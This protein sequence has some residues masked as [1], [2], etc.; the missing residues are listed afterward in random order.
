MSELI[1]ITPELFARTK[2]KEGFR[3]RPY[4]CPT[5][6]WTIGYGHKITDNALLIVF[7]WNTELRFSEEQADEQLLRDLMSAV[8]D[9]KKLHVIATPARQ[10]ALIEMVFNLGLPQVWQFK[11]MLS[12]IYSG[13]WNR[14]A[15]EALNSQWAK[16]VGKRAQEI[17]EIFRKG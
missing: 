6:H 3:D 11:K 15:K 13:D 4:K 7:K 1:G 8:E 2:E 16:Q 17:A 14:A 12:A 9:F 10:D 5:G